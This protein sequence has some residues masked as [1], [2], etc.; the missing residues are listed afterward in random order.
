[1]T[2]DIPEWSPSD[3]AERARC[4]QWVVLVDLLCIAAMGFLIF[5]Y[6]TKG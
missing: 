4:L 6:Y 1:M 5:C 3:N 2:R